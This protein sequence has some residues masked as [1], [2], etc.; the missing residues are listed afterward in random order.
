MNPEIYSE[1]LRRQGKRVLRTASSYWNT[2]AFGVYRA[3]PEHW[4]IEPSRDELR[5]LTLH[6]RAIALRYSAPAGAARTTTNG[7]HVVYTGADYDFE[8]LSG[9]ARKNVRRGL[10]SCDVRPIPFYRYVEEGWEL[11]QDTLARQGRRLRESREDWTRRYSAAADLSGFAVWAAEVNDR[12]AATLMTFQMNNWAY[13]VYQ[14]CH[15]DFL[16]EHVNNALSF[17]VTQHLIRNL[18]VRGVYYGMSSLDAPESV[19]EFK[20]R[21]GYEARPVLQR[22]EFHPYL[23][24]LVN[25]VTYKAAKLAAAVAPRSRNLAKAEGMLGLSME[26][27]R[28]SVTSV[29]DS[30][31]LRQTDDHLQ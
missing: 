27:K 31:Q 25:A 6:H 4:T 12:L 5:E 20:F 18:G 14:Q 23:R 29:L 8:A 3:F 17:V 7:Y 22:V 24:P 15:R 30:H 10:Y 9:W 26:E 13:M 2:E 21:M 1:W 28:G 11:R 19:D 16:R